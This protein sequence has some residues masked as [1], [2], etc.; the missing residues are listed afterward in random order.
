MVILVAV[1][2][3][4]VGAIQLVDYGIDLLRKQSGLEPDKKQQVEEIVNIINEKSA[5]E[6]QFS[7]YPDYRFYQDIKKITLL[8]SAESWVDKG[9]EVHGREYKKFIKA[10][11]EVVDAYLFVNA[12][13]DHGKPLK[14]WDSIYVSLRKELRGYLYQPIDGHLLRSESLAVPPSD[15]TILLYDL[16]N[17]PFIS[18]PYSDDKEPT[19]KNWTQLLQ[20]ATIFQFETFL[21]TQRVGGEIIEVSIGYQCANDTPDCSLEVVDAAK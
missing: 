19:Y 9:G 20:S 3:F 5:S 12:S 14:I 15:T 18:I 7:E 4:T 2:V 8:S 6:K 21:S 13:A 17:I 11:G 10:N 1:V 16:S